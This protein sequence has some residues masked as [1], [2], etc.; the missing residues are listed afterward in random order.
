VLAAAAAGLSGCGIGAGAEKEGGGVDQVITRDF[1]QQ[2]L[3]QRAVPAVRESDTVLR[4]LQGSSKVKTRYGG[5][6]VASIDGLAE[7]DRHAWLFFV[8][9]IAGE[10]P[11]DDLE[12]HGGDAVQ[13]DYHSIRVQG[14]IR[15]RRPPVPRAR[16][17]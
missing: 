1:G 14:D 3:G 6:Y 13:W 17:M 15:H 9:G 16:G 7:G 8:N 11:A 4:L 12:L 5:G 2:R 10:K